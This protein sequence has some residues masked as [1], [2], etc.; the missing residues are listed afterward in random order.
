MARIG[1]D[2][3]TS[4]NRTQRSCIRRAPPG[5]RDY[6]DAVCRLCMRRDRMRSI[7]RRLVVVAAS[8]GALSPALAQYPTR[9][10]RL[11]VPFA[12]GGPT[13]TVARIVGQKLAEQWNQSFI[14]ENKPGADGLIAAEFVA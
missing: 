11:I 12:P 1:R 13:D 9:P 14:V 8:L 10:V 7:L 5:R 3:T 6:A 4:R 2:C